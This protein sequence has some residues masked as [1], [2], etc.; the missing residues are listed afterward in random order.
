M[1]VTG[2]GG[3][4]CGPGSDKDRPVIWVRLYLCQMFSPDG[5]HA[6]PSPTWSWAFIGHCHTESEL[7]GGRQSEQTLPMCQPGVSKDLSGA[8][9]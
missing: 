7:Q 2:I 9:A 6:T 8:L 1:E 3:G 5:L 4:W